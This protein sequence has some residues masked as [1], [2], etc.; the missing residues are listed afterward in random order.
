MGPFLAVH[1]KGGAHLNED[2]C[3]SGAA[4]CLAGQRKFLGLS[5]GNWALGSAGICEDSRA[6]LCVL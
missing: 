3:S 2:L 5:S 6:S 4:Q 1:S